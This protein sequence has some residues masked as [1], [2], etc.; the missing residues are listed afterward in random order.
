MHSM[1]FRL[2]IKSTTTAHLPCGQP[3]PRLAAPRLRPLAW[4][5]RVAD[6]PCNR[7]AAQIA[8]PVVLPSA[9]G[10]DS[11][12]QARR[13]VPPRTDHS[14]LV[15]HRSVARIRMY[16]VRTRPCACKK[17]QVRYAAFPEIMLPRLDLSHLTKRLSTCFRVPAG[18]LSLTA[19][20]RTG[21]NGKSDRVS[22]EQ[23]AS[24]NTTKHR[25]RKTPATLIALSRLLA[26]GPNSLIHAPVAGRAAAAPA[27][28]PK[29]AGRGA[30][31]YSLGGQ[32][33]QSISR[34]SA[35]S[36][37]DQASES[38]PSESSGRPSAASVSVQRQ[39]Q[40]DPARVGRG[41]LDLSS[42][43]SLPQ[44]TLSES[45]SPD[46]ISLVAA[47]VVVAS[48]AAASAAAAAAKWSLTATL[49]TAFGRRR[50]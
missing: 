40:S 26:S 42:T 2:P 20:V 4:R 29:T 17:S 8:T 15:T 38:G 23:N 44:P 22:K 16:G 25:A 24:I 28:S 32:V 13:G 47:A 46:P 27:A 41:S 18:H 49:A 3:R 45:P 19:V 39:L 50:L 14:V 6:Q 37:A 10:A 11:P 36:A 34:T 31:A 9:C 7:P 30:P 12:K 5:F 35:S 33:T 21:F 48:A 1:L 43:S